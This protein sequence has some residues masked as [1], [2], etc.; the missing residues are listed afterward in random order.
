MAQQ[1]IRYYLNGLLFE[2]EGKKL[3]IV[4]TDGHRLS[5]ASTSLKDSQEKTQIIIPRKTILE[6]I[7]LLNDSKNEV[8]INL[9]KNQATFNFE[10]IAKAF[11][12]NIIYLIMAISIFYYSFVKAR[13]KGSL[14]NIGE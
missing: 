2:V 13:K 12:L 10:N 6:L 8:E 14:I 5:F 11:Y 3:N 4:G 7:K 9:S 1:D